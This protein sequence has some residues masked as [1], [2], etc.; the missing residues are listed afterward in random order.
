MPPVVDAQF[1][2]GHMDWSAMREAALA[3]ES[4]GYS[5]L[6][7]VD[8]LAGRSMG[9]E[10][11]FEAFT[12]LGALAAATSRIEL[13]SLVVNVWNREAGISVLGASTV[14]AV[15]GRRFWFGLGAGTSPR[16]SFAWE[17]EMVGAHIEPALERRHDRVEAVL[18]LCS[19]MWDGPAESMPTFLRPPIRPTV[20]VG[21]N[22]VRLAGLAGRRA[23]GVNVAWH[24]PRRDEFLAACRSAVGDRPFVWTTYLRWEHGLDDPE[25]PTRLAIAAAGMDRVILLHAAVPE[26]S[27]AVR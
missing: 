8:H 26:I 14:A 4:A 27:R 10:Q 22:S 16:S 11:S 7:I 12:W 25:H 5:A 3:A 18:D 1:T 6:W 20:I 24:H 17:Q 19:R 21:V 23:D 13:G 2:A 15:S 9:G